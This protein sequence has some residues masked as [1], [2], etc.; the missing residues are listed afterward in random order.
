M[1]SVI[2]VIIL[3]IRAMKKGEIDVKRGCFLDTVNRVVYTL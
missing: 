1:I 2:I 3:V